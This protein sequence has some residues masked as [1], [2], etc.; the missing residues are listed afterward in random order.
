MVSKFQ[1][2]AS[3]YGVGV[4]GRTPGSISANKN[5][6]SLTKSPQ[7]QALFQNTS[8][9][10]LNVFSKFSDLEPVRQSVLS[11]PK[12]SAHKAHQSSINGGVDY[13][14]QMTPSS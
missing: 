10:N 14:A 3:N 5:D 11:S 8:N 2:G 4:L 13:R 12:R 9:A 7:I 1:I 6:Y